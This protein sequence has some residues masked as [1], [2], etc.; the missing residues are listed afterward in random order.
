MHEDVICVA[1]LAYQSFSSFVVFCLLRQ[2][3]SDGAKGQ[4]KWNSRVR[5][6]KLGIVLQ[7]SEMVLEVVG[8]SGKESPRLI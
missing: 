1:A 4:F 5:A 3:E 6:S 2:L 8:S 7:G